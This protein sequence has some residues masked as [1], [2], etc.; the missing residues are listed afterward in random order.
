MVT[1]VAVGGAIVPNLEFF[2]EAISQVTFDPTVEVE[3]REY[4]TVESAS[5]SFS[6]VGLGLAY[7]LGESNIFVSSSV[8]RATATA[9]S[10]YGKGKASG[11]GLRLGAGKEWWVDDQW[12]L[13]LG[14]NLSYAFLW[15]DLYDYS[16]LALGLNFSATYQ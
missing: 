16:A 5:L 9:E 8:G 2:A 10:D 7:Y 4:E 14:A 6:S 12:G 15:D 1:Y 3:G 11:I 13:G